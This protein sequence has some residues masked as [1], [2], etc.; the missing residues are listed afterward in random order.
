MAG[1]MHAMTEIMSQKKETMVV[2]NSLGA[3]HK[4]VSVTMW[5]WTRFFSIM[6]EIQ[7]NFLSMYVWPPLH[8]WK[9]SNKLQNKGSEHSFSPFVTE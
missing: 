9:L 8:D 2:I 4:L 3:G 1:L 5:L 7:E 6:N